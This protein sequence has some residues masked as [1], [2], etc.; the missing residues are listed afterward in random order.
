MA[1]RSIAMARPRRRIS[2]GRSAWAIRTICR[3]IT[4][5]MIAATTGDAAPT[6]T[7][8]QN[9]I[10]TMA[11]NADSKPVLRQATR[12]DTRKPIDTQAHS[13][14]GGGYEGPRIKENRSDITQVAAYEPGH[15]GKKQKLRPRWPY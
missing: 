9:P 10:S 11:R 4:T 3:A 15:K 1:S 5:A 14:R 13:L 6:R 8:P 12:Q 7:Q 2:T